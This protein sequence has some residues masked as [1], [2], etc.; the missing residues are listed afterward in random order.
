MTEEEKLKLIGG[1]GMETFAIPELGIPAIRMTDGPSGV[2]SWG[3]STAYPAGIA[4]AA[5]WDPAL[6]KREGQSLAD[7]A[8][9]RGAR[10]L[11]GPGVNI[12][13]APMNGRNFEYFGEDPYL[14]SR[15]AVG[16][17]EG[18]QSHGVAATVKHFDANTSE[19]DRHNTNAVIDERTLHE[20]YLPAFEA[21][22]KEGHVA[23]VMDSYNLVNGAHMTENAPMNLDILKHS[24][25]FNGVLMSDW[26]ATYDGVA[27]ANAGL[28]LE[29]PRAKSMTPAA[30]TTALGKGTLSEAVLDD[31]VRRILTLVLRYGATDPGSAEANGHAYSEGAKKIAYRIAAEGTVLLKNDGGLLPL[32]SNRLHRIAVIGPNSWPPETGGGGS[33]YTTAFRSSDLYTSLCDVLG[34]KVEV[35]WSPGSKSETD[36]FSQTAFDEAD[37]RAG[38]K[39]EMYNNASFT[40]LPQTSRIPHV[41]FWTPSFRIGGGTSLNPKTYRWTATFTAKTAGEYY[42]LVG[43]HGRDSYVLRFDGKIVLEHAQSEGTAPQYFRT[44]FSKGQHT[45]VEFDYVQRGQHLDAGLGIV[46]VDSIVLPEVK[47]LAERSDAV[48]VSLGFSPSYES[49]AFDRPWELLPGQNE[50]VNAV[51]GVNRKII[52]VLNAGGGVDVAQWID[53]VPAFLHAW[54]GGEEG[55]HAL[56]DLLTGRVSPSGKLPITLERQLED[57]GSYKSYYPKPATTDVHFSEGIFVGYRHFDHAG[58]KPLYPFGF[59]LSYTDFAFSDLHVTKDGAQAVKVSFLVRNSGSRS[60]DEVAQVYVGEQ[61]APVPRP[62]RELKAFRRVHLEPGKSSRVSLELGRRA[63]SYWDTTTHDWK[64]DNATFQIEVGDSEEALPLHGTVQLR[65]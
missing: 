23:A 28:D 62:V 41:N 9:A 22:V 54:Y 33:S 10:I 57:D 35:D 4:L 60:G 51:A 48:I 47:R 7:D 43:A 30:M 58:V 1:N 63:F 17:I 11:L 15:V 12:Y 52:V 39:Q 45:V 6:A 21:A 19:F 44:H 8:K 18:V 31:K 59:G 40:G 13:R 42:V 3:P 38:L 26:N 50:L 32:D 65:P 25:G 27:A 49:E 55:G 34:P 20:I 14:A 64:L 37:G 56:A 61:D 53:H 16:Y 46:A 29:M 36:I 5:T 24:W 2:R